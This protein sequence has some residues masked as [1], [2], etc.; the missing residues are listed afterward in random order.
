MT[1][2]V[3]KACRFHIRRTW[4][5]RRHLDEETAKRLMLATV[6]SR[7]DYC[8]S[9]LAYLPDKYIKQL[10]KIQNAAARLVARIPMRNPIT[11]TL[12]RLHW[13]PVRYRIKYKIA[14]IVHKCIYGQAP[15]YLKD[16][17]QRRVPA[18]E[19]RSSSE[20]ILVVPPVNQTTLGSR[21]FSRSGPK[22]WNELPNSLQNTKSLPK[23]KSALKTYYF[24]KAF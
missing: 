7:L 5:I 12:K 23:F 22:V 20:L 13:L 6:M 14:T 4:L 10:Q 17:I 24:S 19:L 16:L 1:S 11:P 21:A 8:N 18:R 15:N 9:L 2:N 3:T